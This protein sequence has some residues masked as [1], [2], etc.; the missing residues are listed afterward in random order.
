[1]KRKDILWFQR[2]EF[3]AGI[4]VLL[5][6]YVFLLLPE[7]GT[8]L[9][10]WGKISIGIFFLLLFGTVCLL[11]IDRWK[12]EWVKTITV[13]IF[14]LACGWLFYSYSGANW[15][16]FG[17]NFFNLE[18][19]RGRYHIFLNPL[20]VVL[21]IALMSSIFVPII[22]LVMAIFRSFDNVFINAF[23][24]IYVNFFRSMPSIVL[25]VLVYF[26][27]PYIGIGLV[28]TQAVVLALSLLFGAYATEIFR[29]GIE[30]IHHT[31]IQA[32]HALGLTSFQTMRLV[33]L[34]Q[35]VRIVIPP[36]TSQI[37][38]ILKT[39][40]IAY[41][42]GV[43]EL[44]A[45]ARQMQGTLNTSTPLLVVSGIYLLVV[46]PLV[47]LSSNLEK[48]SQHWSGKAKIND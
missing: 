6:A 4:A 27:L 25:I 2:T 24:A 23:V 1:M 11:L 40:S 46:L 34:P 39:T 30:S 20:L 17:K 36:F 14:L 10:V 42:V 19:M 26:A 35:A 12:P 33:V 15:A 18:K 9:V 22:G 44:I 48:R 5:V 29:A 7:R 45:R 13:L 31:Q 37:V 47:I 41:V 21:K 8:P 43:P 28:S 3:F 16:L 38:G 32:A